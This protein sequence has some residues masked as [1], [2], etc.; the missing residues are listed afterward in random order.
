MVANPEELGLHVSLWLFGGTSIH[1]LCVRAVIPHPGHWGGL[2][3]GIE[4]YLG[5]K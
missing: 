1:L 5:T 2:E 4:W 3:M